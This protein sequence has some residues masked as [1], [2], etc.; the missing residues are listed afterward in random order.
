MKRRSS[1]DNPAPA[2]LQSLCCRGC[3]L[4]PIGTLD[5][6][7]YYGEPSWSLCL[8]SFGSQRTYYAINYFACKSADST[9]EVLLLTIVYKTPKCC[10]SQ[11]GEGKFMN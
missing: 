1:L 9:P 3:L 11:A 4:V 8:G 2:V 6:N 10:E 7:Y 5:S